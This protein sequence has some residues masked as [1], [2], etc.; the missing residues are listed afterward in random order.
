[1]KSWSFLT[2]L[3]TLCYR[4]MKNLSLLLIIALSFGCNPDKETRINSKKAKF[5][6]SDASELFFKNV[7]QTYY[8]KDE[9]AT[10]KLDVYKNKKLLNHEPLLFPQIVHN[11]REDEAYIL[12]EF[13]QQINELGSLQL[14]WKDSIGFQSET[15]PL[16]NKKVHFDIASQVYNN[17]LNEKTNYIKINQDTVKLFPDT[18]TKEG[19]RITM[20][21]FYR[22]VDMY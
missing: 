19:F 12:I 9:I 22:L 17:I 21:D 13:D 8:N 20:V 3:P 6:T 7:R 4:L 11:W 14:L 10:A 18:D 2:F 15:F 1:M 16:V 5:K